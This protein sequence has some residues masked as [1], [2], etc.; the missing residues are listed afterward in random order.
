[1]EP[2]ISP[3]FIYVIQLVNTMCGAMITVAVISGLAWIVLFTISCILTWQ[4]V[5]YGLDEDEEGIFR[6]L[7][8]WKKYLLIFFVPSFLIAVFVPSRDTLLAMYAAKQITPH[9]IE[10]VKES[11]KDATKF[12]LDEIFK[13]I[14][15]GQ[16]E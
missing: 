8:K 9:S 5:D 4:E 1:M 14:N 16:N 11:G 2:I 10:Q 12:L 13:R 7:L 15:E 6:G 3:W